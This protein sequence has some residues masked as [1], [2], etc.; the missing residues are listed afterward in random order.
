[1]NKCNQIFVVF[2]IWVFNY[3][4]QYHS[5]PEVRKMTKFVEYQ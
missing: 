2:E 1:M 4:I 5:L 3:L